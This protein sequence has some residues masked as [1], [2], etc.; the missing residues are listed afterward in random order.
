MCEPSASKELSIEDH[1]V[2]PE[3]RDVSSLGHQQMRRP[4]LLSVK[5]FRSAFVKIH[6][7]TI[8][9]KVITN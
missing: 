9:T 8:R 4:N 3:V 6:L 7:Q 1:C 2:D 5:D